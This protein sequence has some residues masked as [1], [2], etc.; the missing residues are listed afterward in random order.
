MTN[1]IKKSVTLSIET[2]EMVRELAEREDRSFSQM[3][4]LL[5]K[6][7]LELVKKNN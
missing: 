6:K 4:E 3:L 5:V 7:Q 2:I 1:K